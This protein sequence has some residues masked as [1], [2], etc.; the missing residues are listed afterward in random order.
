MPMTDVRLS[1]NAIGSVMRSPEVQTELLRRAQ[2]VARRAAELAPARHPGQFE[3]T[4]VA[5]KHRARASVFWPGGLAMEYSRR[6]LGQAV[7]AARE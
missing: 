1:A 7:D 2:K 3:A 4:V 6:I 5:G